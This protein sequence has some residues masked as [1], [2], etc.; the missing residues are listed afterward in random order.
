MKDGT[1]SI[2]QVARQGLQLGAAGI[3]ANASSFALT[4][5]LARKLSPSSYGT[6]AFVNGAVRSIL[7]FCD[8]GLSVSM[9]RELAFSMGRQSG[10]GSPS[11]TANYLKALIV[12]VA[13]GALSAVGLVIFSIGP[14]ENEDF[15]SAG[16]SVFLWVTAPL[17]ALELAAAY[18]GMR[19]I[20]M[21]GFTQAVYEPLRLLA[22]LLIPF[23]TVYSLDSVILAWSIASGVV[24]GIL[25]FVALPVLRGVVR[26]A[27]TSGGVSR[28]MPI[29]RR[30]VVYGPPFVGQVSMPPLSIALLG[31][32][33]SPAETAVFAAGIL[34]S[35]LTNVLLGPLSQALLPAFAFHEGRGKRA[36]T[37]SITVLLN[38]IVTL[39]MLVYLFVTLAAGFLV[40]TA[41]GP[42]FS[43]SVDIALITAAAGFL[44]SVRHVADPLL[45]SAGKVK[46]IAVVEVIRHIVLAV[47][48]LLFGLHFGV[49]GAAWGLVGVSLFSFTARVGLTNA[50]WGTGATVYSCKGALWC[51]VMVALNGFRVPPYLVIVV[52]IIMARL[53]GLV[54]LREL[55]RI[56]RDYAGE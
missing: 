1:F 47:C 28:I 45:F 17:A 39:N 30:A 44:E 53:L 25:V 9:T 18:R 3:V 38:G 11:V 41:F 5:L 31:L 34:F 51:L 22:V 49:I 33:V 56:R 23:F 36:S 40:R 24:L 50:L 32:V 42:D 12:P 4:I 8:F 55:K 26:H 10:H 2:S 46:R 54:G 52:G 16:W 21:A 29:Y 6:I 48:V 7:L 20:G 37:D 19:R 27:R 43:E 14:V 15:G 35:T 13:V